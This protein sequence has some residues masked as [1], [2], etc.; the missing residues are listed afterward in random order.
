MSDD[1]YLLSEEERPAWLSYPRS[2]HR[3]VEQSLIDLR[4]WHVLTCKLALRR[5]EGL[6]NRYPDRQLFPFAYRQDNDELVCWSKGHGEK[7]FLIHDFA[8][9]G[10]E[11][12][13]VFDNLWGWFREAIEE[14]ILW[15]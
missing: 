13:A 12:E 8:S 9:P 2:F 7:V 3:I 6:V 10:F 14:T 4:P 5:F 11:E 15:E 1:V